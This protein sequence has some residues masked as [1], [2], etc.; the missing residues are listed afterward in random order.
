MGENENWK[1]K[2]KELE[3]QNKIEEM[4]KIKIESNC[5]KDCLGYVNGK[6]FE[7]FLDYVIIKEDEVDTRLILPDNFEAETINTGV[8]LA[9]GPGMYTSNGVFIPTTI[10]RGDHVVFKKNYKLMDFELH[11][12]KMIVVA[13]A[14][15]VLRY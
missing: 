10:R 8:V 1:D 12:E 4:N 6:V 13:E 9:V 3:R 15:V 7:V 11:G 2:E 5:P 14:D